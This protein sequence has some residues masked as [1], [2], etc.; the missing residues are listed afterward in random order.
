MA[1]PADKIVWKEVLE[2]FLILL[3]SMSF[4][5]AVAVVVAIFVVDSPLDLEIRAKIFIELDQPHRAL[6]A[7]IKLTQVDPR[8][9]KVFSTI[10]DLYTALGAH[11]EAAEY[12]AKAA[13]VD[14]SVPY[15]LS[16]AVAAQK[17]GLREEASKYYREVLKLDPENVV[18]RT[19]MASAVPDKTEMQPST[20]PESRT[21]RET[22]QEGASEHPE[23]PA[24]QPT[25]QDR[26]TESQPGSVSG[27]EP[28]QKPVEPP[29]RKSTQPCD[30]VL[31]EVKELIGH[32]EADKL[33]LFRERIGEPDSYCETEGQKTYCFK[34]IVRGHLKDTIEVIEKEDRIESYYFG[35]CGCADASSK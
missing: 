9:Y 21:P 15:L 3:A 7:Y 11:K 26:G 18:A 14:N 10:G 13:R 32:G 4:L 28:S 27:A 12:Y 29:P 23:K 30:Q 35:S 31:K 20:G 19:N 24:V 6:N 17:S 34:C 22:V 33:S 2:R 16:A 25:D 8:N 5:V 1:D